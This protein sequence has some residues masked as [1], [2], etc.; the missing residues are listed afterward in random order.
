MNPS[1]FF[2]HFKSKTANPQFEDVYDILPLELDEVLKSKVTEVTLIDVRQ[3]SEYLGEL[4]H[5]PASTL[6]VLDQ[7]PEKIVALPKD[8][9][10]IFICRSGMRSAQ[11]TAFAL[12]NGFQSVFNLQGGMLLW[13]E[14]NLPTQK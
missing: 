3:P 4:G 6:I 11:A 7:L 9:T 5:I 12:M 1:N 2:V 13:N 8:K 10:V 14:L